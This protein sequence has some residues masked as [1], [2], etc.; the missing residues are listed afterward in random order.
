MIAIQ[1]TGSSTEPI[2]IIAIPLFK[3]R[4]YR[5]LAPGGCWRTA[6]TAHSHLPPAPKSFGNFASPKLGET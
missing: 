6:D 4:L 3:V 1:A 2:P 5:L